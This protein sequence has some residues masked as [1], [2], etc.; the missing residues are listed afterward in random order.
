MVL[1]LMSEIL[2]AR[3]SIY[4]WCRTCYS[5]SF[6]FKIFY[7]SLNIIKKMINITEPFRAYSPKEWFVMKPI[8]MKKI[9]GLVLM[10]LFSIDGKKFF[11]K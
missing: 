1:I 6:I 3:R 2:D 11:K 8:K 9:I 4:W 10:R 7:E 5:S